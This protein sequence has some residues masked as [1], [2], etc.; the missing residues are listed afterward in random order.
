MLATPFM[1]SLSKHAAPAVLL[2]CLMLP[3]CSPT[4][5][6]IDAHLQRAN[7]LLRHGQT[8]PAESE[9]EA[10]IRSDPS[11]AET[12]RAAIGI[13][14]G[15]KRPR[16]AA[17]AADELLRRAGSGR[18]DERLSTSEK[19][20]LLLMLGQLRQES[21][22]LVEAERAY[23]DA[24]ALQPDH[25]QFLNALAYLYAD[26]GFRLGIALRLAR[27]AV[28][29][30]PS[31]GAIVDTLGWAQY[32]LGQYDAAM[33]TLKKAVE[34]MPDDATLRYHLGAAY[35]KKG[36]KPEARIELE[37]SLLLD[38]SMSDAIKLRKTIH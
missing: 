25:P 16:Q 7:E 18:L 11:R 34:F 30:A 12:Y 29:H 21:G 1:L 31:D 14:W 17:A 2:L 32:R 24:L 22:D 36:L 10:A 20:R 26:E 3:G 28:A 13:Y 35:A 9:V 27:R 6:S 15:H 4:A 5:D 19:A 23:R 38:S 37:K 33:R 8:G